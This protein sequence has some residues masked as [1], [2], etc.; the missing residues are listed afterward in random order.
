MGEETTVP[1]LMLM[2]VTVSPDFVVTGELS[3]MTS[4]AV[5]WFATI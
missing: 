3:G 1:F 5:A 2:L 4:S